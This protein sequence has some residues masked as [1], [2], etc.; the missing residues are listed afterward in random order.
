MKTSFPN[1]LE[2]LLT[3][4]K[5][6]KQYVGRPAMSQVDSLPICLMYGYK[7]TVAFLP[8][9]LHEE[10]LKAIRAC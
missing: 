9:S 10:I 3:C 8:E 2:V 4:P 7:E 5:C 6:G 1:E